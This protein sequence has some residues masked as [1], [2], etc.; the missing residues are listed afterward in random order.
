[1]RKIG[2]LFIASILCAGGVLFYGGF[3][4]RSVPQYL[5]Q[6]ALTIE[7]ANG[8]VLLQV[9]MAKTKEQQERGLM[10]RRMLA[11][12]AGMLF[13]LGSERWVSL[14][15]KNTLIPL[16][17]IFVRGNGTIVQIAANAQP[18]STNIVS[19]RE[20]VR[21]VLEIGG[22]R[23]LALGLRTGNRMVNAIFADQKK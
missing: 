7:T 1:M 22:G 17:M 6:T 14:W 18:L 19:S 4:R 8:P 2:L 23:A 9:E 20:P 10:F 16:D 3:S 15:M 13:D 11:P 5:P 12:D 21:A